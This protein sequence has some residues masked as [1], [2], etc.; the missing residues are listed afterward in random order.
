LRE[1][2]LP[3][4]ADP[5]LGEGEKSFPLPKIPLADRKGFREVALGFDDDRAKEQAD[6]CLH[7]GSTL[8]SVVFKA[9]EPKR[10]VIPWDPR[11]ALELWQKRQAENGESLPDVFD[12]PSDIFEAP[13]DI[14]GRNRLVLKP[15]NSEELLAYTTDDE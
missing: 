13:T 7:C 3:P 14:V 6:R 2:R 1:G 10:M 9:V 8:P 11:R 12:R 4:A 15:L 5:P